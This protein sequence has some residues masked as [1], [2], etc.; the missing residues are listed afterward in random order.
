MRLHS[1]CRLSRHDMFHPL[2][3]FFRAAAPAVLL[4]AVPARATAVDGPDRAALHANHPTGIAALYRDASP[5]VADYSAAMM[6][7]RAAYQGEAGA[8][9]AFRLI[10]P[11]EPI[12]GAWTWAAEDG[13]IVKRVKKGTYLVVRTD[14]PGN[15]FVELQCRSASW[16]KFTC[17]DGRVREMSAPD[18]NTMVLNGTT[19][20]R[21][22]PETE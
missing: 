3:G 5:V 1:G 19:Y 12:G 21:I 4:A 16:P 20:S 8:P 22:M 13:S 15:W 14:R 6:R 2:Q 17:S 11:D 7:Y 10:R 9:L 18:L